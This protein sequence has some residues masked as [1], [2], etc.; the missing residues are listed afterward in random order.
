M[1]AAALL[2]S[3]PVGRR[4]RRGRPFS[5]GRG[6]AG[7]GSGGLFLSLAVGGMARAGRELVAGL[8]ARTGGRDPHQ[9]L[10]AIA[11]LEGERGSRSTFFMLVRHTH[12]WDGTHSAHYQRLLPSLARA[13]AP[14]AEIGVHA[15]T[16]A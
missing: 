4:P 13:L 11:A 1:G 2:G 15:S 7:P 10:E 16:A 5:P 8:R 12:R 14:V 9:N 3:G 6:S